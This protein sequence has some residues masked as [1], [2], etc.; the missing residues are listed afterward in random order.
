MKCNEIQWNT[1]AL[2]FT[3]LR[4]CRGMRPT[5]A[6]SKKMHVSCRTPMQSHEIWIPL[7]P[8]STFCQKPSKKCRF[9]EV[10]LHFHWFLQ[11]PRDIK[12][13]HPPSRALRQYVLYVIR[14]TGFTLYANTW[15]MHKVRIQYAG[16]TTKDCA[17]TW[18]VNVDLCR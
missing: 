8:N 4:R 11:C 1:F 12:R 14:D 9:F 2:C 10:L 3:R 17:Y 13:F 7:N 15:I 6:S 16:F 5:F 18:L